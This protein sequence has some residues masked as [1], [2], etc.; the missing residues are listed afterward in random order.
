MRLGVVFTGVAL[1]VG[2]LFGVSVVAYSLGAVVESLMLEKLGISGGG[3]IVQILVSMLL[4]VMVI[5]TLLTLVIAY[6]AGGA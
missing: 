6:A 5:A 1:I 4:V 2:A 3:H